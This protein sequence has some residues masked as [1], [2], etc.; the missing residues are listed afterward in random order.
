MR[1]MSGCRILRAEDV[2][3]GL[4]PASKLT[5]QGQDKRIVLSGVNLAAV[6]G[7]CLASIVFDKAVTIVQAQTSI[8]P[9]AGVNSAANPV[10]GLFNNDLATSMGTITIAMAAAQLEK[11][12]YSPTASVNIAAGGALNVA[13]NTAATVSGTATL[14]VVYH[15]NP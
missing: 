10:I 6:A 13:I 7:T 3:D 9:A 14:M 15:E 2:G 8:E 12:T 11:D 5:T 1:S 4:L